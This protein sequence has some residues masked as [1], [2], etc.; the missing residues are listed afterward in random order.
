MELEAL[1]RQAEITVYPALYEGFGLPALEAM[2]SGSPLAC[3]GNSALG[4]LVGGAADTFDPWDI[5]DITETIDALLLSDS[6]RRALHKLGPER[7]AAFSWKNAAISTTK[8]YHHVA[9]S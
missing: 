1:Y 4:E 6:R 3:S 2:A 5:E 9:S 8:L 7:A